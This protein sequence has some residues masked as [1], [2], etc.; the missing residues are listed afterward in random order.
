MTNPTAFP[1]SWPIRIPRSEYQIESRFDRKRSLNCATE[2]TLD[3]IR[4]MGGKNPII[5][6]NVELRQDGLP[7]SNRRAPEDSGVAVYFQYQGE[8]YVF[9]C[10][11][12]WKVQENLWAIGKTIEAT[13]AIERYGVA[14]TRQ[15]FSGFRAL[16]S[17]ETVG[18]DQKP[19]WEYLNVSSDA[20]PAQINAAFRSKALVMHPDKGGRI[21]DWN[22]LQRA[23]SEAKGR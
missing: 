14:D 2:F 22:N 12:Y 18:T 11:K 6:T 16:P 7:Y 23:Y 4:I 21:E 15:A 8:D 13:R 17:P 9:A 19:W 1:L 5:S 20:T 10:D 3:Q